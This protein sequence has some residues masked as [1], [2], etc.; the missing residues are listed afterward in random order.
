M[1]EAI[2]KEIVANKRE[3]LERQRKITPLEELAERALSLPPTRD[4]KT[5]LSGPG[6]SLIA[7][8]KKASPSVG[9]IRKDFDPVEI[10]K[11]Y[12]ESGAAAISVLTE[13]KYFQGSL[14]DLGRIKM[15]TSVPVLRKDF[16]FDD[17]QVY[18]SRV[19]GADAVL[20]I[21]AILNAKK[22]S[23]LI[24]L[25]RELELGVLMEV[26]TQEEL[27]KVS[28]TDAEIIGINNRNLGNFEVD[29]S[30][31]ARLKAFISPDK[32]IVSE[33]GISS[34]NEVDFLRSLGVDAILVG[35]FLMKGDDVKEKVRELL[36]NKGSEV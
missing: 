33:S 31:T 23:R 20:L 11:M 3:E 7:E 26:H 32:I 30:T 1:S 16:I 36:E 24:S 13:S 14:D 15:A 29:I 5:A 18:E 22:M 19:H 8:V 35:E 9:V 27:F 28:K 17:Y 25:A 12:E 21:A 2:L 4:F 34:S 6:L 10:A